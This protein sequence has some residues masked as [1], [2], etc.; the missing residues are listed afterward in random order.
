MINAGK[1]YISKRDNHDESRMKKP[2]IGAIRKELIDLEDKDNLC[3]THLLEEENPTTQE[4]FYS[5]I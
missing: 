3:I 5:K 4:K 2:K 1:N